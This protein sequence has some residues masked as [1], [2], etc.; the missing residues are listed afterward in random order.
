MDDDTN[1]DVGTG[2]SRPP[3]IER[4]GTH[5]SMG[6]EEDAPT[7]S[8]AATTPPAVV[9]AV[10]AAADA[11]PAQAD[12]NLNLQEDN[13]GLPTER[14]DIQGTQDAPDGT[15]NDPVFG[16]TGG[17][18]RYEFAKSRGMIHYHSVLSSKNVGSNGGGG[19]NEGD[20]QQRGS[21]SGVDSKNGGAA[22]EVN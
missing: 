14:Q 10:A 13:N 17:N 6:G 16:V 20:D 9:T 18:L 4:S 19:S 2:T 5:Y 3:I 7:T 11:D 21:T 1:T 8:A 12:G 15:V 22:I